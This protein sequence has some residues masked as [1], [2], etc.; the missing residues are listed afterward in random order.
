MCQIMRVVI[1][2]DPRL[3]RRLFR[4]SWK[5]SRVSSMCCQGT[6]RAYASSVKLA[7]KA[8]SM[9]LNLRTFGEKRRSI[10]VQDTTPRL[11]IATFGAN[12][13]PFAPSLC[14]IPDQLSTFYPRV[15]SLPKTGIIQPTFP[16]YTFP[17]Y[18][19]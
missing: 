18:R 7:G 11:I 12:V 19:P 4:Y 3:L 2:C 13:N 16:E 14:K 1:G 8:A 9:T 6:S 17:N 5:C 10:P 15:A